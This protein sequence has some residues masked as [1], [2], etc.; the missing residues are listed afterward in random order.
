MGLGKEYWDFCDKSY[1][2]EDLF[3][4]EYNLPVISE[5][6]HNKPYYCTY[7]IDCLEH[8]I[9][10]LYTS[11]KNLCLMYVVFKNQEVTNTFDKKV[12][13]LL[14]EIKI[15]HVKQWIGY[16]NAKDEIY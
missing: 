11:Y 12:K 5:R 3:K 6:W 7:R 2:L 16:I 4:E 14:P 1:I 15:A 10:R 8:P 9:G 13:L